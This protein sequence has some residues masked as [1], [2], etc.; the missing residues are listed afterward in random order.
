MIERIPG[1]K[2]SNTPFT[3]MSTLAW[4]YCTVFFH[5][6]RKTESFPTSQNVP[7]VK[8]SFSK[9]LQRWSA[10]RPRLL[11]APALEVRW[12]WKDM[13]QQSAPG[14]RKD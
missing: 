7:N 6:M 8:G 4:T 5:P 2:Q 14:N 10:L 13:G 1:L 11:F 9:G 3:W 12:S